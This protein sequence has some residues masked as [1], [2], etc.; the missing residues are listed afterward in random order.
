MDSSEKDKS[1]AAPLHG[2]A[3]DHLTVSHLENVMQRHFTVSH[4][5]QEL[6]SNTQAQTNNTQQTQNQSNS[7]PIQQGGG[8]AADQNKG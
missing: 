1:G 8:E 6:G 7:A 2:F 5:A 3:Q 4:I